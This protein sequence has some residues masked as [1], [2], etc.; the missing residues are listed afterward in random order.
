MCK[1]FYSAVSSTSFRIS[2]T[3][4]G[5]GHTEAYYCSEDYIAI[6]FGTNPALPLSSSA[7]PAPA[8]A[9]PNRYCGA[10]LTYSVAGTTEGTINTSV[11]PFR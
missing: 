11:T 8:A 9:K 7:P 4:S 3:I 5:T 6:P 1:I 10:L 2:G